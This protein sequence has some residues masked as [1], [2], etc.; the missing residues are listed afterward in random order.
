MILLKFILNI[1]YFIQL[2]NIISSKRIFGNKNRINRNLLT[3]HKNN[4]YQE[5]NNC[6]DDVSNL[7]NG[8]AIILDTN[9]YCFAI[10]KELIQN[11]VL[12][13]DD[14]IKDNNGHI[15]I[16]ITEPQNIPKQSFIIFLDILC[17]IYNKD[18]IGDIKYNNN[19]W[20]L[21]NKFNINENNIIILQELF[22]FLD[23]K[24]G[25]YILKNIYDNNNLNLYYNI[26][27]CLYDSYQSKEF[28]WIIFAKHSQ[29][30][31]YQTLQKYYDCMTDYSFDIDLVKDTFSGLF[32]L[33]I[34][35]FLYD[36]LT[37]NSF[38]YISAIARND[39]KYFDNDKQ[40]QDFIINFKIKMKN[41]TINDM[42]RSAGEMGFTQLSQLLLDKGA[43]I[44]A[45]NDYALIHASSNGHTETV[46]L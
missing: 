19:I 36:P 18:I 21:L 29:N 20:N 46:Q 37:F 28:H 39:Y 25:I 16:P 15:T 45:Y 13:I 8:N 30:K 10:N 27:N 1:F 3:I 40:F 38:N 6:N 14:M 44:H 23:F 34:L 26:S 12:L 4:M 17:I 41:I 5:L 9:N 33:F 22:E 2:I 24:K 43:D 7:F 42:F 31:D 32:S 35:N 11:N